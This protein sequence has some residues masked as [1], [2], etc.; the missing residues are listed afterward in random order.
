MCNRIPISAPRKSRKGSA[1]KRVKSIKKDSRH[2]PFRNMSLRANPHSLGKCP[3]PDDP[4]DSFTNSVAS[5]KH[6]LPEVVRRHQASGKSPVPEHLTACKTAGQSPAARTPT[7]PIFVFNMRMCTSAQTPTLQ[8]DWILPDHQRRST[9][10]PWN[11]STHPFSLFTK[12]S[13]LGTARAGSIPARSQ[14]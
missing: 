6:N 1:G 2:I 4:L 7:Q 13:P 9:R 3:R 11:G 14:W 12:N 5:G 8:P 10:T